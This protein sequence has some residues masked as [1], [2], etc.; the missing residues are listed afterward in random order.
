M[1]LLY[2]GTD[3]ALL[4]W[5]FG[6]DR[7]RAPQLTL[8]GELEIGAMPSFVAFARQSRHAVALS[9]GAD[10]VTSLAVRLDG[11]LELLSRQDCPGGPAYLSLT[12]DDRWVLI[13]SYGGGTLP[14][15]ALDERG[16]LSP[17]KYT[18]QSGSLSHCALRDPDTNTIYVPSKGTDSIFIGVLDASSGEVVEQ[19][20]L[21]LPQGSGPRH[22]A[23]SPD[24]QSAYLA[25][26]NDC[27]LVVFRRN[28]VGN[29][30]FLEQIARK[31]VLPRDL[32]PTDSGADVHV[33]RDSRFIY[34]S[35]RGHDSVAI[36]ERTGDGVDCLG[37]IPTGAVPR[38]FC[39]WGDDLMFVANQES[40]SL[41]F[42]IRDIHTG[43]LSV[44]GECE[45]NERPFWVGGRA[46]Y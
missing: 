28:R 3:R 19:Q 35:V 45:M 23:L 20:R 16:I 22:L 37:H 6:Q 11:S 7:S 12:P 24:G 43:M 4:W 13:A 2:T 15:F 38:N 36:F 30:A 10:T 17:R 42:F 1:T 5:D 8:R 32:L 29:R 46:S 31:S 34:V 39:L 41:T 14:T 21:A 40:K 25:C 27:S 26:E 33:S 44:W 9:E 18:T